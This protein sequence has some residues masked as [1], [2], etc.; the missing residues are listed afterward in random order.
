MANLEHKDVQVNKV[1]AVSQDSLD[2]WAQSDDLVNQALWVRWA[3]LVSKVQWV[4]L[5]KQVS[6]VVESQVHWVQWVQ[7]VH[8]GRRGKLV[9]QVSLDRKETWEWLVDLENQEELVSPDPEVSLV[10]QVAQ[11]N[12]AL[13]VVLV[14][15]AN[16][17]F[18][19]NLAPKA[20]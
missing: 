6:L 19:D 3:Q 16:G 7:W 8:V 15:R 5:V 17:V 18:L 14:L 10:K 9:D 12:Q 13:T 11:D 2:Q 20:P 1:L 4:S